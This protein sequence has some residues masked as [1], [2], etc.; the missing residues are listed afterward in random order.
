M[1]V[2]TFL[3]TIIIA[4]VQCRYPAPTRPATSVQDREKPFPYINLKLQ[5]GCSLICN[6]GNYTEGQSS[7]INTLALYSEVA[8]LESL[9]RG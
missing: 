4:A 6:Y 7:V 8:K 9:H 3:C 5:T 2:S 1:D